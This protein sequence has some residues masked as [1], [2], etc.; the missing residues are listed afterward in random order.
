MLKRN[1][2]VIAIISFA[3]IFASNVFGQSN[4]RK[5]TTTNVWGDPHVNEIRNRKARKPKGLLPYLEQSNRLKPKHKRKINS[6]TSI[7]R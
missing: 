1:L 6:K 3:V 4:Q 5:R 2:M 7:S